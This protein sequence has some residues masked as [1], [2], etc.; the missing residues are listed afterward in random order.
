MIIRRARPDEGTVVAAVRVASWR[1]AYAGLVPASYLAAMPADEAQWNAIANKEHPGT[2]LIVC[3]ADNRIVGFACYGMARPP[4]FD[5]SGELYATYFLPDAIGKGYGAATLR[6]AILGLSRLGHSDMMLWV[7]EDNARGQRFY[8]QA[9]GVVVAGSR[10]SFS[11][12]D[13]TIWEIAYGFRP[14]PE[15]P[16][17]R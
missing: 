7:M 14:L 2:E 8:Q 10:R 5:Y 9:G 1:T 11:I 13:T 4:C 6:A 17:T 3:E 16:S 12:H 15:A